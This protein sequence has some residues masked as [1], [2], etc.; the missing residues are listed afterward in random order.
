MD[1]L[2]VTHLNWGDLQALCPLPCVKESQLSVVAAADQQVWVF[3]I[4]LQAEQ[5]GGWF[6]SVLWLVGVL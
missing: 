4:V 2:L 6:Q 1:R 3:G 5:R